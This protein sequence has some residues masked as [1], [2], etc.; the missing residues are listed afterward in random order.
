MRSL[1]KRRSKLSGS[2]G[3]VERGGELEERDDVVLDEEAERVA[4]VEHGFPGG[5]V[6][7][8]AAEGAAH[9]GVGAEA[10]DGGGGE[11]AAFD[12]GGSEQRG[13]GGGEL[14]LEFGG[15]FGVSV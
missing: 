6:A 10:A 7:E 15:A 1:T 13:G 11:A 3:G 8:E 14:A 5:G 12:G 9:V 4:A 2:G